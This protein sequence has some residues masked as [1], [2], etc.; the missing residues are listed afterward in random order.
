MNDSRRVLLLGRHAVIFDKDFVTESLLVYDTTTRFRGHS[1][2]GEEQGRYEPI[3][4]RQSYAFGGNDF[5]IGFKCYEISNNMVQQQ[6]IYNGRHTFNSLIVQISF[7]PGEKIR[8]FD[9]DNSLLLRNELVTS[10]L[11]C[12]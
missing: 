12:S 5:L 11:Q 3:C 7:I 4:S 2:I 1:E 10:L 8:E 6:R 9:I